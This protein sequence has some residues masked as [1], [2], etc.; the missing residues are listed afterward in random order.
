MF[1]EFLL[2][3]KKRH[4]AFAVGPARAYI[5]VGS[6]ETTEKRLEVEVQITAIMDK[7]SVSAGTSVSFVV[8]VPADD[9]PPTR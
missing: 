7:S 1:H 8:V 3:P 4:F 2:V 6:F 9:S 5:L